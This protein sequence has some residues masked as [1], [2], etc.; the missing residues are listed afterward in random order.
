MLSLVQAL[1]K[2][3]NT[4]IETVKL[5]DNELFIKPHSD[6]RWSISQIIE[7]LNISDKSAYIA[8]IKTSGI[9]SIMQVEH[10]QN[11]M[12]ILRESKEQKWIAPEGA[13]PKGI[14][15]D[16][17]T[18][19]YNF[20]KTRSRFIAFAANE[21]LELLATGFEHPRLGV[22]TR[23]QWLEFVIWHSEHHLLQVE[24]LISA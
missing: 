1:L 17:S 12:R 11:A 18:A 7:H 3:T 5:V 6:G 22:L 20:E 14:F 13:M 21:N 15:N 10:G 24:Q 8:I 16:V 4:I 2:S 19:L 23:K 9:P